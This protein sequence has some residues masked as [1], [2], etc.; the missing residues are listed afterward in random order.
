MKHGRESR[1]SRKLKYKNKGW[2]EGERRRGKEKEEREKKIKEEREKV[3]KTNERV[4]RT[5]L[6]N[7]IR[8]PESIRPMVK[9]TFKSP[10]KKSPEEVA[11]IKSEFSRRFKESLSERVSNKD[12]D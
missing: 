9:K 7:S 1:Y 8:K 5:E 12:V 11:L 2:D 3:A 4:K 6:T 10:D